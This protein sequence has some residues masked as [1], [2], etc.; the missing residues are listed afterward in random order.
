MA[1][2]PGSDLS[3]DGD[4][5]SGKD[6]SGDSA[7]DQAFSAA[8]RAAEGSPDSDDAW[9]HV[10]QLAD[11]LQRPDE[12]AAAYREALEGKLTPAV[13]ARIARRA[14]QFHEEWFGDNP[15]A[16]HSLLGRI[17]EVDPTADWAFEQ[18]TVVL[19]VG[20]RWADLLGLY[21]RALET[22]TDKSRRRQLLDDAAH[23]AKDFADDPARAVDYMQAQLD[24]DPEN[25]KLASTIERLLERQDRHADLVEH[26]RRRLPRQAVEDARASRVRIAACLVDH[27]QA[28]D[29]SLA[30]LSALLDEA[31]SYGP[32]CEQLERILSSDDP[33]LATRMNA[34]GLLR[35][36]YSTAQKSD[37]VI[38]VLTSAIAFAPDDDRPKL[39]REV[40]RALAIKGD[41]AAALGQYADLLAEAPADGDARRQMRIL[42]RRSSL[43]EPFSAALQRAAE[44]AEDDGQRITLL[45]EAAEVSHEKLDDTETGI[46]LY[47]RIVDMS[48]ADP[49]LALSAAHRLNELLAAA[50][51]S[52]AR[53]A[54]LEQL[55]QLERAA[56][57]RRAVLA[58][59]A[60]LASELGDVDRA[61]GAWEARLA[62]DESDLEALNELLEVLEAHERWPALSDALGRRALLAHQ[63]AAKRA[64]LVRVAQL[65]ETELDQAES[66]A[67]TWETVRSEFGNEPDVIEALDRLLTAQERHEELSKILGEAAQTRRMDSA[68][69]LARRGDVL[70]QAL[71]QAEPA[72]VAYRQA[73]GVDAHDTAAREG[74]RALLDETDDKREA[75]AALAWAFDATG[76]IDDLLGL[77]DVRV[78]AA[79]EPRE[80]LRI[81]REA[82]SLHENQRGDVGAAQ[83]ALA[84]ALTLDPSD[85]GLEQEL[86]RVAEGTGRWADLAE[87]FRNAIAMSAPSAGRA[88][89]LYRVEG[90]IHEQR[91]SDPEAAARAFSAAA[92]LEPSSIDTQRSVIRAASKAGAWDDAARG[93]VGLSRA[94]GTVDTPTADACVEAAQAA[95][96]GTELGSALTKALA[97]VELPSDLGRDLYLLAAR[98]H[99]EQAGDNVAAEAAAR[100]AVDHDPEHRGA[101]SLLV[102]LQREV[103]SPG[104]IDTLLRLDSQLDNDVSAIHEAAERTR[105]A[106][107][108]QA[109]PVLEQLFGKASR[110]IAHEASHS[111]G[112]VPMD[113]ATWA[114]DELVKLALADDDKP[115]AIEV[116]L[117]ASN[118]PFPPEDVVKLQARAGRLMVDVGRIDEAI[119]LL[120]RV[121]AARASDVDLIVELAEL[122]DRQGRLLE[123][124][125]L[126]QRELALSGSDERKLQLRL[127]LARLGGELEGRGGRLRALRENLEQQPGHP[128][129]I[130]AVVDVMSDTGRF[131]ALADL[132]SEQAAVLERGGANEPAAALW[133]RVAALVEQHFSDGPRAIAALARV[134]EL[135]SDHEALDDLARLHL[136]AGEP[137]DAAD[138]LRKRLDSTPE[139]QR[140]SILLR[141][142]RAQISAEQMTDAVRTLEQAFEAAPKNAEAR[143]LLLGLYRDRAQWEPL[144]NALSIATEHVSDTST[145][146]AYAREAAELYHDRLQ[147]PDRAVPVLE[148]AHTLAPDDRKLASMLAEGLRV[149]GRLDE[150]KTL[151]HELIEAFGRRRSAERAAAHLQLAKVS[152]ALGDT[153]AAL[154]QLDAASKMD[155]GNPIIMRTLASM[156]KDSGELDRAER[157]YRAL[158]LQLR[159]TTAATTSEVSAAEVLIEL[160]S[161][162]AE[163]GQAEQ[164]EELVESALE[165]IGGDDSQSSRVQHM[166]TEREDWTLL[167]RVL[168][169]RL[170]HV[171]GARRRAAVLSD[172]AGLYA[173]HLERPED[174]FRT[175]LQALELDA[176]SPG[177]HDHARDLAV[178][179]GRVDEYREE[180]SRLLD[181]SRR[182]TDVLV[183]C[184]L[185]LRLAS[186]HELSERYDEA[187]D[188]LAQADK[189][190]VREVDVM[191]A[192]ARL[193]GARGDTAAQMALLG[194]LAS[195]GEGESE[196]RA[197]ALY[198]MAE[199]L[200]AAE[201]T[202]LDGVAT[203][204]QALDEAPR[205]P[206]AARILRRATEAHGLS[207]DLLELYDHVARQLGDDAVL[208][209]AIERRA[210]LAETPPEYIREGVEL[211][212]TLGEAERAE[213]MMVRAVET[214]SSLLDGAQRVAW[215]MLGLARRRLAGGDLAAA[216][217]W[218]GEAAEGAA[219][220]ELFALGEEIADAARGE[221]GD[222][223]LA[224]KLY[225]NL[226]ERNPTARAAWEPLAQLYVELG[227]V[228]R[229]HRLVD[230]TL[231]GLASTQERNALRM[232]LARALGDAMDFDDAIEVLRAV[233]LE[234]PEHAEAQ[235]AFAKH[236]EATG[237]QQELVELL[238]QQ[239]MAAQA[240]EDNRATAALALR[241][242]QRLEAEDL[243][244]ALETYETGLQASPTDVPLLRALLAHNSGEDDIEE[245]LALLGRLVDCTQ[246]DDAAQ[247]AIDLAATHTARGDTDAALEAL[248]GGA[249]RAPGHEGL[250][251]KLVEAFESRGDYRGLATMLQD[252]AADQED[253][254][255]YVGLLRQ[256][257]QIHRELLVD[258]AT[259]AQLLAEAHARVPEDTDLSL[260]LASGLAAAG[261]PDQAAALVTE[262]LDNL[263]DGD[264]QRS[265]LLRLR[266]D[267]S[268]AS[269]DLV[270]AVADLEAALPYDAATVRPALI[271]ALHAHADAATD[272]DEKRTHTLRLAE[273]LSEDGREGEARDV[274][275]A[276]TEHARKDIEA[277]ERLRAVDTDLGAWEAVSKTCARLVAI[278]SD[279]AQVDAALGLADAS[280]KMGKPE[281]AKPGLEH[282]RRKQPDEPRIRAALRDVYEAMGADTDL[283]KL[284]LVDAEEVEDE[285]DRLE[286]LRR[287]AD[288][289]TDAGD[290]D[291]AL[292]VL[293]QVL[294]IVP[295]D[296]VAT[297]SL[298]DAHTALGDLDRADDLLD[299]AMAGLRGRRTPELALLQHRKARLAGA[300]GD[301]DGQLE[302]LQQ[303]YLTDKNNGQIAAELADLAEAVEA[304]DLAV[305][306]LRTITLLED[307][308]I[309]RT[310]AFLRQAKIAH[311]RGDRQRAVL[312]ARKAKHEDGEDEQV[313]AFLADL[314]EG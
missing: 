278:C 196:T 11:Q 41:D 205:A 13:R 154:E 219:E 2:G 44:A 159:R 260:E 303:A 108:E 95:S 308:P 198:R 100:V 213:E 148:R 243:T 83:D 134:I 289:M 200:L 23:V 179:L 192:K 110:L 177:H 50:G 203:L 15:E 4:K 275:A 60:R 136:D 36:S 59:A 178:S 124:M 284:L 139:P 151:L 37:D 212:T 223:T 201:D 92:E 271:D 132:L 230:E 216:V 211:A 113:S 152:H 160:S 27:L 16:M 80:A 77:V 101:L 147:L 120:H 24:L 156:A 193:A 208:L 99:R 244:E 141:L 209:E 22:T 185:L 166:L 285:G 112:P 38:R 197:D 111:G 145:I 180:V 8:L 245:R 150:A 7:M 118:L 204:R 263:D 162:A 19:T 122:C 56:V 69:L 277:L 238:R 194:Q 233:L 225:E 57:V 221:G 309:T 34:L 85:A 231:D 149:A 272:D 161:I 307:S 78:D 137:A 142:A 184:E 262:L 273:L 127:E 314:G 63:P 62:A 274:L 5:A 241:L 247:T 215:A 46:E 218:I 214:G 255:A 206:R 126:R 58:D 176:G 310:E 75:A 301:H 290:M 20:E 96:A 186:A 242:G 14:V 12:V 210:A 165:T 105:D 107:P 296:L 226:L 174:A 283:A 114:R 115:R 172:L 229:L 68:A 6:R 240:R 64:D 102:E 66:A 119:D 51:R 182:N 173:D 171:D 191:R 35:K 65:Q 293:E 294:Q 258:P 199:V 91:L 28:Y 183:R 79:R 29:T 302:L 280:V 195:M 53:L 220:A 40:A 257:A 71:A 304:F 239:L 292:P 18:L 253:P 313:A 70:R 217:K 306:V 155:A 312:W 169:T 190:G 298:A 297:V 143:K 256:A 311:R 207:G 261:Q 49:S 295:G 128:E 268:R 164:A 250:R 52:E 131:A 43:H 158:L 129:S 55:G 246:G 74:L 30:E 300:R 125:A 235:T 232:M 97:N 93:L 94:R 276:W 305:K 188:L 54:V 234:A 87:C 116:L 224:A 248:V 39:R 153:E 45:L 76:D 135:D 252:A 47:Q 32:A 86:L 254:A 236:L 264:A 33:D 266:A 249:K 265:Q 82:A 10:E 259:S 138:V 72:V 222:A 202:L 267:L 123:L 146:L 98:W 67:A 106:S 133:R 48:Q 228:T 281:E 251:A 187:A 269:G 175:R 117:S 88:A 130:E 157:A 144:A 73:L 3:V 42:A 189:T 167:H 81:L 279:E 9:A 89:H 181:R 25:N 270:T 299:Q 84:R 17:I 61:L 121:S 282:A 31:P 104:L 170:A 286:M 21:D 291:G 90:Q 103:D 168:Q 109:R 163:R 237:Q 1:N 287:A 140:V 227:D 26:W 288:L